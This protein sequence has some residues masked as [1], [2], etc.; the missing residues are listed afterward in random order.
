[1]FLVLKYKNLTTIL[2]KIQ[3]SRDLNVNF[4]PLNLILTKTKSNYKYVSLFVKEF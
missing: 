2:S 4:K 3:F 1:M